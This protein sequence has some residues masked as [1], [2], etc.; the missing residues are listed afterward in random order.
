V[1]PC[2]GASE[3]L[4]LTI[5]M[6][7]NLTLITWFYV[8]AIC[9]CP[10]LLCSNC[11]QSKPQMHRIFRISYKTGYSH[12]VF[13]KP[14][15]V[16]LPDYHSDSGFS[17]RMKN[18]QKIKSALRIGLQ[19]RQTSLKQAVDW[20]AKGIESIMEKVNHKTFSDFLLPAF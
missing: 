3:A 6:N 8:V 7:V 15:L 14:L 10:Q 19:N 4:R 9:H 20:N 12:S 11:Y 16:F 5:K 18:L 17:N 1:F 13:E 2:E